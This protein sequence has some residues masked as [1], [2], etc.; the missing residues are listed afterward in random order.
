MVVLVAA[1]AET[2]S[3]FNGND[4]LVLKCQSS[5]VKARTM[6]KHKPNENL[7]SLIMFPNL[8]ILFEISAS[9]YLDLREIDHIP[10]ICHRR[11]CIAYF[12]L[13]RHVDLSRC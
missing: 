6:K 2:R 5:K 12:C 11:I 4:C 3:E 9:H 10:V 7:F 1:C 8:L 13:L